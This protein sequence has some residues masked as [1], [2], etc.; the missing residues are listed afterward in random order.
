VVVVVVVVVLVVLVVLVVVE[1]VVPGVVVLD[2]KSWS[3]N[4]A[5]SS[6]S[7]RDCTSALA[8]HTSVRKCLI[9]LAKSRES[10]RMLS[11]NCTWI[12]SNALVVTK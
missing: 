11:E 12:F 6:I 7:L 4:M 5:K 10:I 8:P 2:T 9:K 1:V 3:V